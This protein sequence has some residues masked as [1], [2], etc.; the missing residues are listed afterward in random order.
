MR[1]ISMISFTEFLKEG[2]HDPS[3]F[4]AVF[5]AGGPGSGKSFI[6]GNTALKQM[7]F[8][9]I[10]SDIAFERE[11]KKA[12]LAPTPSNISS[13]RGQALRNKSKHTTGNIKE[14]ALTGRLGLVID[15]TGRD[16][17]HIRSQKVNL[18]H[19][20][21]E[22][23]M[24]FVNTNLETAQFRNNMRERSLDNKMVEKMWT[25]VQNNLGKFQQ[26]FS[27]RLVIIDNNENSDV[28]A[29]TNRAYKYILNWSKQT[30]KNE[31]AQKWIKNQ[32]HIN[33]G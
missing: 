27:H 18:E 7:G 13:P 24:V 33:K 20:G 25:D 1:S 12:N 30:P 16:Y 11:L 28:K 6:V 22:T 2:V 31:I 14:L 8:K 17:E 26:L 3:I 5:M 19:L 32:N 15:G 29:Q 23:M 9:L 4:K 21:Y 10:N